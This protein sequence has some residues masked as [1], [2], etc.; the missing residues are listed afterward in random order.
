MTA[1]ASPDYN[2]EKVG[3]ALDTMTAGLE[4]MAAGLTTLRQLLAPSAA[5][6]EEFDPKDPANKQEVGG[7]EKLTRRGVEICYRLFDQGTSRYGVAQ[8]MGISF[9]AATHRYAAWEKAG[10]VH[11]T[12]DSLN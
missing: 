4:K 6:S 12:K 1:I 10:G 8:A 7:V 3:Q 2:P 11:R 5:P 9:G